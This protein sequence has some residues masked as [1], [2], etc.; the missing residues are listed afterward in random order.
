MYPW[1]EGE[2]V[3]LEVT[4]VGVDNVLYNLA[5]LVCTEQVDAERRPLHTIVNIQLVLQQ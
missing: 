5:N 3:E 2:L 4:K 1:C